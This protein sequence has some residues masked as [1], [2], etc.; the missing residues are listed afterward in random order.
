MGMMKKLFLL[1]T[2]MMFLAGCASMSTHNKTSSSDTERAT[3]CNNRGNEYFLQGQYDLAIKEYR[4]AI[5]IYPGYAKAHSNMGYTFFEKKQYDRAI[6]EFSRAIESNPQYAKAYNNRGLVYFAKGEYDRAI[7]DYSKAIEISPDLAK[8]YDNRGSIYM[9]M[10][11]VERACSDF[12]QA[13]DLGACRT[14][15]M[16]AQEGICNFN[17]LAFSTSY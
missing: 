15:E 8:P 17:L 16:V 7:L 13:C 4:K 9:L 3:E 10:G 5:E 6:V 2:V 11:E 1:V 12:E 14:Y